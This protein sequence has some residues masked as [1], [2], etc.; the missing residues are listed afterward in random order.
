MSVTKTAECPDLRDE[1]LLKKALE[2]VMGWQV[3]TT[4][5]KRP[6]ETPQATMYGGD[7]VENAVLV[8]NRQ[9]TGGRYGDFAVVKNPDGTL[10]MVYDAHDRWKT[11]DGDVVNAE[12]LIKKSEDLVKQSYNKEYMNKQVSRVGGRPVTDWRTSGPGRIKKRIAL[13]RSDLAFL[14]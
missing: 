3:E 2:E 8:V 14:R 1:Q 7:K 9:S 5:G 6:E 13:R 11:K 12:E 4:A 10:T